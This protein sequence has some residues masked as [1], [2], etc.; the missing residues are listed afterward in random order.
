MNKYECIKRINELNK[1]N[2]IYGKSIS[3]IIKE[4]PKKQFKKTHIK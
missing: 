2:N 4:Y 1:E 3:T